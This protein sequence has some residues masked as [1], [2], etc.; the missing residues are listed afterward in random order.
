M[1]VGTN[2]VSDWESIE[3]AVDEI[4][5]QSPDPFDSATIANVQ[6]L[7]AGCRPL[8]PIPEGTAKGYWRTI[9]L[10]WEGLEVEV[11]DDHY[12]FYRFKQGSTDIEHF[13]HTPRTSVP[14]ELMNRLPTQSPLND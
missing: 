8:C 5:R 2:N 10:W 1:H 14:A 7:I 4:I 9:R 6:D 13:N 3:K 11:F 12:E